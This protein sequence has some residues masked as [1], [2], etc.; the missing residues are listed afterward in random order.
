MP[1]KPQPPN[2][3]FMDT[4]S[5]RSFV[6]H[7]LAPLGTNQTN[8]ICLIMLVYRLLKSSL[9]QFYDVAAACADSVGLEFRLAVERADLNV[10]L[11]VKFLPP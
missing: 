2:D 9:I 8:M 11:D 7:N 5:L 10:V 4:R 6:A 1:Q 3:M